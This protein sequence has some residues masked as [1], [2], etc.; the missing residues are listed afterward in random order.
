MCSKIMRLVLSVCVYVY[1]YD[2]VYVYMWSYILFIHF[3]IN[4]WIK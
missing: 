4:V 2:I 3:I 1:N